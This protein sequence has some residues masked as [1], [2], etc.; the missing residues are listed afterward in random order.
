L[1]LCRGHGDTGTRG[2]GDTGHGTRGHGE[3]EGD[4]GQGDKGTRDK[5]TG[6]RGGS[7]WRFKPHLITKPPSAKMVGLETLGVAA[8]RGSVA[9]AP[10]VP[11]SLSGQ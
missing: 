10:L 2:H 4:R 7:R 8:N 9:R 6:D 11:L 5:G 1:I 3:G